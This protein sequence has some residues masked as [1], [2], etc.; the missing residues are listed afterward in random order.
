MAIQSKDGSLN[1]TITDGTTQV[2]KQAPDGSLYVSISDGTTVGV[3]GKDGSTRV[4]VTG[5]AAVVTDGLELEVGGSTYTF[6]V[7]DGEI[8][9]IDVV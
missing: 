2:P 7:V 6:T 5:G 8:T 4:T 9:V 3:N 1:V